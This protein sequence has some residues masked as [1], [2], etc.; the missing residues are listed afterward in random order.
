[1]DELRKI[2]LSTKIINIIRDFYSKSNIK[3]ANGHQISNSIK[4]T[5]GVL[6]GEALSP[7]L[8]ALFLYDLE[9]FLN[10]RGIRGVSVTHLKEILLL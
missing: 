5:K 8:F 2:W 10:E 7:L 9:S 6:Q 4:T 1:M 3:I